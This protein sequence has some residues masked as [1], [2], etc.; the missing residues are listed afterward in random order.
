MVSLCAGEKP[1]IRF[2]SAADTAVG[3]WNA[4]SIG[5]IHGTRDEDRPYSFGSKDATK[6]SDAGII[7]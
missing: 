5:C 4:N 7:A 3:L 1:D 2:T 6:M